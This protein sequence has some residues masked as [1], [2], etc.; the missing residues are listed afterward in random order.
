MPVIV[1]IIYILFI[2]VTGA[3]VVYVS[4]TVFHRFD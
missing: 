4:L 2:C 3:V 1:D